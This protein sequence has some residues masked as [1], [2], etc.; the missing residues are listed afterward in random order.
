[1]ATKKNVVKKIDHLCIAL[2]TIF[3][4]FPNVENFCTIL[5]ISSKLA[6]IPVQILPFSWGIVVV[7]Y[8]GKTIAQS[9][10]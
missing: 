1:L 10:T 3:H 7:Q 8:I 6:I 9:N 2:K 4:V 5:L